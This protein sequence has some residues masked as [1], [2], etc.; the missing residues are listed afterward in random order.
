M[1]LEAV[2]RY[3]ILG[4]ALG[5]CSSDQKYNNKRICEVLKQRR[6]IG[7]EAWLLVLL[8]QRPE[9]ELLAGLFAVEAETRN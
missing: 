7:L 1:Y 5:C 9:I 8:K 4:M 6:E 3:R 2:V